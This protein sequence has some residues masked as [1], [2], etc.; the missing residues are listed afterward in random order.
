V[1]YP[2]QRRYPLA[3]QVEVIPLTDLV[4][5]DGVGSRLRKKP[6]KLYHENPV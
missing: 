3:D 5:G 1:V 4:Q 2:G 6:K